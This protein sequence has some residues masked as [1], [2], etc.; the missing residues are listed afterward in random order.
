VVGKTGGRRTT[1]STILSYVSRVL[2][3]APSPSN[4]RVSP[5]GGL[6]GELDRVRCEYGADGHARE[7]DDAGV[8][9]LLRNRPGATGDRVRGRHSRTGRIA[10]TAAGTGR[11][12]VRMSK[13]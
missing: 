12:G 10:R 8:G 1:P 6:E 11:C 4:G 5:G 3:I 7:C 9:R 13:R 2:L